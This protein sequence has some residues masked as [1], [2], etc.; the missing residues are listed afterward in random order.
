[1][2]DDLEELRAELLRASRIE[3]P[4]SGLEARIAKRLEEEP[5]MPSRRLVTPLRAAAG[6]SLLLAAASF[7]LYRSRSVEVATPEPPRGSVAA[8]S[9]SALVETAPKICIARQRGSGEAPLIDD[10]EDGDGAVSVRDRRSGFWQLVTDRNEKGPG[11]FTI[12]PSKSGHGFAMH[13]TGPEFREWGSSLEY[14][15]PTHCYDASA[16]RGL[17]FRAKGPG[18]VYVSAREVSVVPEHL[19]GTCKADCFNSHLKLVVLSDKWQRF[20]V[21]WS[22][23]QQRGY[24]RPEVDVTS[25]HSLQ[26]LVRPEDSPFDVWIDDVAFLER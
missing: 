17:T 26:F 3:Q 12:E 14:P 5:R 23:L 18:R 19:Q 24:G 15:F 4:P 16:Y 13:W 9:A 2:S 21:P 6:F 11:P 1:V 10:F 7:V 22:E 8:P 20:E 25:L